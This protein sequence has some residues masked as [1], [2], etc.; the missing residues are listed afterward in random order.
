[1][2]EGSRLL[3]GCR[4]KT[5][6]VGSN[7]TLSA[8]FCP[9]FE[10]NMTIANPVRVR[11]APSPTGFLHVG[12]ARTALFN[13]LFARHHKGEFLLRI[14]DTDLA[15]SKSEMTDVILRSLRWLG[16]EW[17][18]EPVFQAV[19][20]DHHRKVCRDL[21]NSG[22]AYPC[23]CTPEDLQMKREKAQKDKGEYKYDR[24][25]LKLSSQEIDLKLEKGIPHTI[26]F[27]VPE[28]ETIFEDV[29]RGHI[30]V[31]HDQIE[32]FVI[33]RSNN[34]PV[35]QIAVVVD[36]HD[37][38]ITHV[39]RG[40]DHL[41][42]TPKQILLYEAL[43]WKIPVF[44][45]VPMI[46]GPDKKRLSKRHGA[47]SIEEYKTSGFL[48][49]TVINFLAL[50][51]WSPGENRE[52]LT[53][54]ELV[55]L[56]SLERI[57]KNPA[58]LD[59]SKMIWMNDVYLSQMPENQLLDSLVDLFEEKGWVQKESL[60][61]QK[62]YLSKMIRLLK[63]RAKKITDFIK[64]GKYFFED[65]GSYEDKAVQKHWKNSDIIRLMAKIREKCEP[66]SSW[67]AEHL[68]TAIRSLADEE[69]ISAGK[70][71]HPL[72]LALT[73][74]DVSP[75]LFELME[76]LGK[77]RVLRRIHN[78]MDYIERNAGSFDDSY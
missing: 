77:E 34:T 62:E 5:P 39:I 3:S 8:F 29:I 30:T 16:L 11:F 31:K 26:R 65:P 74:F 53:M 57:S 38:N 50:L 4:G 21:Y 9:D 48:S 15:R 25:C 17:D 14:E 47:D 69:T 56:F 73:G 58:I 59:E 27:Q 28:G 18:E 63:D 51:G 13:Y 6:T 67:S 20:M 60:N 76:V 24:L 44:A 64:W 33:L 43:E 40:D 36:D 32:D 42:N 10:A 71:I 45:H 75:G 23:F 19:R 61:T 22:A 72:R 35:Y 66:L 46:L 70:L 2:A 37:M 1:M 52:L 54:E 7:P 12:G 41:S 78:A 55:Q 49:Q 68:E